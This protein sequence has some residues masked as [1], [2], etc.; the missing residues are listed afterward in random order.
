M[1]S[2]ILAALAVSA[3][4]LGAAASARAD[5]PYNKTFTGSANMCSVRYGTCTGVIPIHIFLAKSGRLYS[6]L[7]SEGGQV[8]SLGQYIQVGNTQQRFL[9]SGNT[10]VFEETYPFNGALV[11]LHGYLRAQ[12]GRCSVTGSATMN[13]QAEPITY[14][15]SCQVHDGKQ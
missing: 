10:L 12:G 3:M 4:M 15:G 11:T 2:T 9:V 8:F 13:G 6:F 5:T 1:K 14:Q 7:Q